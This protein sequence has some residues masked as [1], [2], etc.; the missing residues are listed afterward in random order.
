MLLKHLRLLETSTYEGQC[1]W[2]KEPFIEIKVCEAYV[3]TLLIWTPTFYCYMA[4][5]GVT[6][7]HQ[8]DM[9]YNEIGI[10]AHNQL[11]VQQ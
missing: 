8:N 6:N 1:E 9:C 2:L 11:Y 3:V 4:S 7:K 5:L 10:C